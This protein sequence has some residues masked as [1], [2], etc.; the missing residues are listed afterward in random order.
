V[1]AHHGSDLSPTVDPAQVDLPAH[2][3][4]EDQ[5][6]GRPFARERAL[7]LDA[8]AELSVKPFDHVRRPQRFPLGLGK[9]EEPDEFVASLRR[10]ARTPRQRL[11]QL[12]SKAVYAARAAWPLAAYTI[13]SEECAISFSH[14]TRDAALNCLN[15]EW[16]QEPVA[17][18]A[19]LI[20]C[21]GASVA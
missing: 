9:V 16:S 20:L 1:P 18:R 12:R 17:D 11:V 6:H 7:R 14:T 5:H 3:E 15:G 8:A 10:F 2:H 4:A 13:R 21:R 19:G